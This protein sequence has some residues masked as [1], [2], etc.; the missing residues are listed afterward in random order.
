MKEFVKSGNDEKKAILARIEEEVEKLKGSAARLAWSI[1]HSV[2][3]NYLTNML[4]CKYLVFILFNHFLMLALA[5][6]L[7][8]FQYSF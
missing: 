7:V 5:I 2:V 4:M 3:A 8:E 1:F 6:I